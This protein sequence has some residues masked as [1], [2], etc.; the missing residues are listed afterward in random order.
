MFDL[1]FDLM[2]HYIEKWQ[3][4]H[5]AAV[6]RTNITYKEHMHTIPVCT[7]ILY[8]PWK[9]ASLSDTCVSQAAHMEIFSCDGRLFYY[10]HHKWGIWTG[11]VCNKSPVVNTALII[12]KLERIDDTQ[13]LPLFVVQDAALHTTKGKH[14]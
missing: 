8:V 5:N 9:H 12:T 11:L 2:R 6:V 10:Y 13:T 3:Y 14:K 7:Y 1:N 4:I